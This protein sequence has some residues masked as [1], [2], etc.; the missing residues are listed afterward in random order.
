VIAAARL[1]DEQDCGEHQKNSQKMFHPNRSVVLPEFWMR[2]IC[3]EWLQAK[4]SA[5]QQL[6]AGALTSGR[7]PES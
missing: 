7:R 3:T 1:H 5:F 6:V 4:A 2:E